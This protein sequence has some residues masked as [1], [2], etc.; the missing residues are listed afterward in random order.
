MNG[1]PVM[2]KLTSHTIGDK[3]PEDEMPKN[4]AEFS[5]TEVCGT[6]GGAGKVPSGS[7]NLQ[8]EEKCTACGGCGMKRLP[9]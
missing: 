6:C 1:K 4:N 9:K 7:G 8:Y 3:P 5:K 2:V